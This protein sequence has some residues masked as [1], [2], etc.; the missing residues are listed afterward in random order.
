MPQTNPD[1]LPVSFETDK[2]AYHA[3]RV[4]C[5]LA[6]LN[7]IPL[8][9]YS[10]LTAKDLICSCIFQESEFLNYKAPGVPTKHENLNKD[11]SLSSTD[12]GIVQVNDYFHI[13]PTG[14]PFASV[15]VV[16][17]DPQAAVEWM[18]KCYKAGELS[19]WDSYLTGAY[20]QWLVPTSPMWTLAS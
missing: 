16:L 18:I 1:A 3:V 15:E 13:A 9:G 5:D 10:G 4:L 12:W 2:L 11:G 19:M 7:Q 8:Q 20:R 6:G 14:S 17:S